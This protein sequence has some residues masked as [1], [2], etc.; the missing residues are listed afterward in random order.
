MTDT[1]SPTS[2]PGKLLI[3][4]SDAALGETA[5][6][7]LRAAA[8]FGG[9]EIAIATTGDRLDAALVSAIAEADA[10][11]IVTDAARGCTFD[12]RTAMVVAATSGLARLV[13]AVGRLDR[14]PRADERFE[15]IR[16]DVLA[17]EAGFADVDFHVVPISGAALGW[18]SVDTLA[19]ALAVP[20]HGTPAGLA[21]DHAD[22]FSAHVV[23]T[24]AAALLP[25]RRY[26]LTIGGR[27]VAATVTDLR[28]RLNVFDLSHLAARRLQQEDIGLVNLST[29]EA[30]DF[31]PVGENRPMG[32]FRIAEAGGGATLAY[33]FIR[34][35]LRRATNLAWQGLDV[36]KAARRTLM[37]QRA[38]VL[39]FTGLSGSGKSTVANL[40]EKQLH[41][42]GR[43]TYILDGDNVRHG[44]NRDLGFTE[45]DRVENIRRVGEVA[46]LFV[47]AGVI[48]LAAFISPFRADRR[49][50]RDLV[51]D[52]EF[53]EIYM[54]TPLDVCIAR[55]P[56][57]LYKKALAGQI[58]NFTGLDS[59]YEPPE[60]CEIALP[61]AAA[62][63][64]ELASRVIA[65]LEASGYL[66]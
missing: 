57:G 11:A 25:G 45:A 8:G 39:W 19:G 62:S 60:R 7:E 30:I 21:P 16:G 4:A 40:V 28:H 1:T 64:E 59:P 43:F 2:V 37:G 53:L 38:C 50:A 20:A 5:A 24:G 46:K 32:T 61:T 63:P 31:A 56:K 44:L 18:E 9:A 58:K 35:A 33:G 41:A 12:L 34:F 14:L 29:A 54:E 26:D 42:R 22:Q 47:D 55:D 27:T 15:A 48:V 51:G 10:V 23:W 13:V 65:H 3:V 49:M 6:A 17:F 36:D 66:A 52:G